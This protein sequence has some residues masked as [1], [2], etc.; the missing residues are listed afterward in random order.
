MDIKHLFGQKKTFRPL[1]KRRGGEG[2]CMV[3]LRTGPGIAIYSNKFT[4]KTYS[5]VIF[6]PKI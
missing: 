6:S 2:V 1:L 3:F 4:K 5:G